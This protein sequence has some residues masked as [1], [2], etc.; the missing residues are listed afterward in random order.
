[1]PVA[2]LTTSVA[3]GD[4]VDFDP[5]DNTDPIDPT[6]LRF[7]PDGASIRHA[8]GHASDVDDDGDLDMVLHFPTQDT[9]I[10][11][12][13]TEATLTG[14]TVGG[15]DIEGTDSVKNSGCK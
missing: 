9:G 6:T 11:C 3:D 7:G 1:M 4:S 5:F 10:A 15:Q 14:S 2:I 8:I 13:D 12:G